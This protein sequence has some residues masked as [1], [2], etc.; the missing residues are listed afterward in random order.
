MPHFCWFSQV[1]ICKLG[2]LP[3]LTENA[4]A[5]GIRYMSLVTK[6]SNWSNDS[7]SFHRRICRPASR[8][9]QFNEQ[10]QPYFKSSRVPYN[11]SINLDNEQVLILF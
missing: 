3:L 10:S 1:A 4:E 9:S 8:Y 2:T 7:A 5:R 11:S 6:H